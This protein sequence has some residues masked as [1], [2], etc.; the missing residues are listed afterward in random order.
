MSLSAIRYLVPLN[1]LGLAVL[2]ILPQITTLEHS[3]QAIKGMLLWAVV[4]AVMAQV[5]S[6]LGICLRCIRRNGDR[7]RLC[8]IFPYLL[9]LSVKHAGRGHA[10]K[11][12]L[13]ILGPKE[14]HRIL[15]CL[16]IEPRITAA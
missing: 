9:Y 14:K 1:I 12:P 16:G 15:S 6:Y 4:L 11:V 10:D 7:W 13:A 2:L 3:Y 5:A 8:L